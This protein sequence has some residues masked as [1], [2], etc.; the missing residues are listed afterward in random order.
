MDEGFLTQPIISCNNRKFTTNERWRRKWQPIPVYLPGKSRGLR[1]L[2]GYS[3]WDC[4]RVRHALVTEQQPPMKE[5]T[6]KSKN[7]ICT[8]NINKLNA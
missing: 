3:P 1:S 7:R 5:H 6:L 2:A 8:Y 4:K